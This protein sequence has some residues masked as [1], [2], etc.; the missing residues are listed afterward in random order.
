MK[1]LLLGSTNQENIYL[2]KEIIN[3]NDDCI[4]KKNQNFFTF[5]LNADYFSK[6]DD[7]LF[8]NGSIYNKDYLINEE[9][10]SRNKK[11]NAEI[12][13]L[14]LKSKGIDALNLINGDWAIVYY[15]GGT[16]TLYCFCD[17]FSVY[18]IYYSQNNGLEYST[19]LSLLIK[20]KKEKIIAN[21]E[22]LI[23]YLCFGIYA[24]SEQTMFN[25][26]KRLLGGNYLK[27]SIDTNT[28]EIKNWYRINIR[29]NNYTY[30]KN[31]ECFKELLTD[32]IKIRSNEEKIGLTLSGGL[33]SSSIACI[34][35]SISNRD[36][37]I[38]SFTSCFLE[39]EY[40]E[41]KYVDVI[42]EKTGIKTN[43]IFTNID[44]IFV[45]IEELIKK[46][47]EPFGSLSCYVQN[48]VLKIARKYG[49]EIVLDGQG[50]D[51]QLAGYINFYRVLFMSLLKKGK[52]KEL[53]NEIVSYNG[54]YG[55]DNN[56]FG[57]KDVL[58]MIIILLLPNRIYRFYRKNSINKAFKNIP[59][60]KFYKNNYAI[61]K[62][63]EGFNE[64][65][66][67][68]YFI[69]YMKIGMALEF[70][71]EYCASYNN[72]VDLRF[73]FL[74]YRLVDFLINVPINQK[75][76]CGMR[77][78]IMRDSLRELL[79]EEIFKRKTKL[80][81][82]TPENKWIMENKETVEIHFKESIKYLEPILDNKKTLE[83][84]Y[85]KVNNVEF[86]DFSIWR[87]ICAGYWIKVFN[88]EITNE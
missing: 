22:E 2:Y 59:F 31:C 8:F 62:Y 46:Y 10:K 18:P 56:Y 24:S 28:I 39:K 45:D 14:L 4:L 41:Q 20:G 86:G 70:Q 76:R 43:K 38:E 51:E 85:S 65:N 50:A 48:E 72:G 17:R 49:F 82:S 57:L 7:Y 83:W 79:P 16:K 13:Y 30:N 66:E 21:T 58:K 3:E 15:D 84:F 52:I 42:G 12:V 69:H 5:Y 25:G 73:P 87:F 34:L 55:K 19:N 23:A 60:L 44:N 88:V 54:L 35:N 27:Y 37:N 11:N 40:D 61:E 36:K 32:A 47:G 1:K 64:S 74:D 67:L 77:K 26:V 33:D 81:Y 63:W 71:N 78:A 29:D 6:N 53:K 68:K 75:I 80:G 9:I